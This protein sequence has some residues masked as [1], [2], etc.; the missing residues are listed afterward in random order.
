MFLKQVENIGRQF[1]VG[2]GVRLR[3]V[4]E[5]LD[6]GE[7]IN[8]CELINEDMFQQGL[9]GLLIRQC[10]FSEREQAVDVK[11]QTEIL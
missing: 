8:I 4:L 3:M 2:F 1:V 9:H 5:Q 6:Q 11:G 10:V 7:K